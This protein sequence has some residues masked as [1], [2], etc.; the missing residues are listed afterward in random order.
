[1][2]DAGGEIRWY[3]PPLRAIFLPGDAHVS[4]SVERLLKRSA[5]P[6]HLTVT[7]KRSSARAP[8]GKRRGSRRASFAHTA[9]CTI[10]VLLTASRRTTKAGWSAGFT[11]SL[12]AV[13]ESM[14]HLVTDAS[15][16]CF[17]ALCRRLDE[18]GFVLHDAQFITPHL[19]RLGVR[20][21]SRASYLTPPSERPATALPAGLRAFR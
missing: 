21:V 17:A 12:S 14:F 20:E 13:G 19:E 6:W 3:L 5:S 15:K 2:A 18:R 9:P 4:R 16:V 10:A 7:S 8:I 1:M 11:A